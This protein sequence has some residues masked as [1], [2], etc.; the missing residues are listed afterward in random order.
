M[1]YP[2][3]RSRIQARLL[4]LLSLLTIIF[5]AWLAPVGNHADS[6]F[7]PQ[8]TASVVF[9]LLCLLMAWRSWGLT[10]AGWISWAP[11]AMLAWPQ[12]NVVSPVTE[13]QPSG[14]W[15]SAASDGL[16]QPVGRVRVVMF[17]NDWMLLRIR[18]DAAGRSHV[19]WVW[20]ESQAAPLRWLALRRA[21]MGHAR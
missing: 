7:L 16:D 11:E 12:P 2:V 20:L 1:S 9:S 21:L 18:L 10:V 19:R 15:W 5:H 13:D 4:S 3:G 8:W 17:F 6:L 14:W